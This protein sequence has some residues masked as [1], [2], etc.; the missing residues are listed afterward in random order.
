LHRFYEYEECDI[1]EVANLLNLYNSFLRDLGELGDKLLFSVNTIMQLQKNINKCTEMTLTLIKCNPERRNS[2]K[3][4]KRK[5]S[6][7]DKEIEGDSNKYLDIL[8]D[9]MCPTYIQNI[10]SKVCKDFRDTMTRMRDSFLVIKPNKRKT[11][12]NSMSISYIS[13]T[14]CPQEMKPSKY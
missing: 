6:F 1:S 2:P 5:A 13:E 14:N 3:N 7:S 11:L 9:E 10:L 8:H 12:N 4:S